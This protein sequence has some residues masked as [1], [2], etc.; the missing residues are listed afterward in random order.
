MTNI[1]PWISY[2]FASKCQKHRKIKGKKKNFPIVKKYM[3]E[4]KNLSKLSGNCLEIYDNV[5][6][7]VLG[8]S[9]NIS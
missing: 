8:R 1:F 4:K 6:K 2:V 5:F 9:D 3:K 7:H